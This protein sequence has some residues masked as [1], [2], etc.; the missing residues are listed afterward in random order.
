M[1]ML[2]TLKGFWP[3]LLW[4]LS[5]FLSCF[6]EMWFHPLLFLFALLLTF[7]CLFVF[8]KHEVKFWWDAQKEGNQLVLEQLFE[9]TFDYSR[10]T[11]IKEDHVKCSGFLCVLVYFRSGLWTDTDACSPACL[12]FVFFF[13]DGRTRITE[14]FLGTHK[15]IL[16][17]F[18]QTVAWGSK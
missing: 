1:Y 10:N 15:N 6:T 17:G 7:I 11:K 2:L 3:H 9:F 16:R 18:H 13:P 8:H 4:T 14:E 12:A 5:V